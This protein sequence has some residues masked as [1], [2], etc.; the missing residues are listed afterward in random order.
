MSKQS[1][2]Q[3]VFD[4]VA[5]K[6]DLMNSLMSFGLHHSWK[7]Q[8]IA[9]I[10]P[11]KTHSLLDVAGGTGDIAMGFLDCGGSNAIICDINPNMLAAGNKKRLDKGTFNKY[12]DRLSTVCADVQNLP[13]DDCSFDRVTISFG[14]R[15]VESIQMGLDEMF[16]VLKVGGKF[17]CME[18]LRPE[19]DG[20]RRKIYDF[21][22][23][24][25]IPAIGK[26]IV[27]DEK[28]YEYLVE[29][30]RQFPQKDDF[31]EMLKKSGFERIQI[32]VLLEDVVAI[33]TCYKLCE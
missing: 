11:Y 17:L 2:V 19:T 18:F 16:R 3:K 15:N 1:T 6:Y 25:I 12:K 26:V 14:I 13:F 30:I 24:N 20:I 10:E 9:M 33:Y 5:D 22:S 28:P 21:F 8:C 23:F 4:S 29:S 31:I 7:R 32:K 27:G